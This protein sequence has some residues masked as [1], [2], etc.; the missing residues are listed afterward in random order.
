MRASRDFFNLVSFV[1]LLA[2]L[3]TCIYEHRLIVGEQTVQAV[4]FNRTLRVSFLAGIY[5]LILAAL[6]LYGFSDG[7][8]ALEAAMWA[9]LLGG[10]TTVLAGTYWNYKRLVHTAYRVREQAASLLR[11]A[12]ETSPN[13][14]AAMRTVFSAFV[15]EEDGR[16]KPEDVRGLLYAAFPTAKLSDVINEVAAFA[17]RGSGGKLSLEG[18]RE[19]MAALLPKIRTG[20]I[21]KSNA[22]LRRRSSELKARLSS[23]LF[24]KKPANTHGGQPQPVSV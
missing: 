12:D 4:A 17:D 16:L 24:P 10:L 19:G 23:G 8:P 5:P 2:V 9:T 20:G 7:R 1:I 13:F 15:V 3:V 11:T 21:P 22:G 18:F 6:L 14:A